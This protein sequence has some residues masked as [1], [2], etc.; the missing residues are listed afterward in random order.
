LLYPSAM[1]GISLRVLLCFCIELLQGPW[2]LSCEMRSKLAR[3]ET[4]DAFLNRIFLWE[5]WDLSLLLNEP[6]E[7]VIERLAVVLWALEVFHSVGI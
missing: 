1:I 4:F 2:G 3:Q 6:P 7:I 5:V